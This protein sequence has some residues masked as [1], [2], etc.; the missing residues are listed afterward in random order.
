MEDKRS[1]GGTMAEGK[2][3]AQFAL[4]AAVAP[5]FAVLCAL[6]PGRVFFLLRA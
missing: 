4:G 6:P 1:Y 5:W 2:G 3:G